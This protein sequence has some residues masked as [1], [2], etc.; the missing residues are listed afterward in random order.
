VALRYAEYAI[1]H[2]KDARKNCGPP[3]ESFFCGRLQIG[4]GL[5]GL[6]FRF[7]RK[8]ATPDV[9]NHHQRERDQYQPGK[10]GQGNEI[11]SGVDQ[12]E[13]AARGVK[14]LKTADSRGQLRAD[15]LSS[16]QGHVR[17]DDMRL[18][19]KCRAISIQFD[20][21]ARN[22]TDRTISHKGGDSLCAGK[23]G[24]GIVDEKPRWHQKVARKEESGI[25]VVKRNL[26]LVVAG[27]RD[28][29][30]SRFN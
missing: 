14:A 11:M 2:A 16:S 5:S 24:I 21:P 8:L 9:P 7:T 20:V 10:Y 25:L 3:I 29:V 4:A 18:P 27:C 1:L 13:L 26:G 28:H 6:A 17:G 19:R 12:D 30:H 22:E 15:P 23:I